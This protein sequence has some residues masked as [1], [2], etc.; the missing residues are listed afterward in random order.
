MTK[1]VI[2]TITNLDIFEHS[3]HGSNEML[4]K[5]VVDFIVC[6]VVL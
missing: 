4:H 1:I 5:R 6:K 3:V 2:N